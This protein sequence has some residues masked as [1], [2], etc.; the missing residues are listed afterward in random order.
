M[1]HRARDPGNGGAIRDP[2]ATAR[3]DRAVPARRLRVRATRF[4]IMALLLLGLAFA[5]TAVQ[6]QCY[7]S[8]GS[9]T[10]VTFSPPSTITIPVGTPNNTVIYT[11]PQV[12]PAAPPVVTCNPAQYLTYGVNNLLGSQPATSATIFPTSVPGIGYRLLHPDTSYYLQPYPCCIQYMSQS[13]FSVQSAIQLIKTGPVT[14]GS[15]LPAGSFANW[16]WGSLTPETFVMGN[17][18]TFAQAGCQV[19]NSNILVVLPTL[20]TSAFS[21]RNSTAGDT[22]FAIN[23]TCTSGATLNI[24]LDTTRPD[25]RRPGVIRTSG[26]G[27]SAGGI[28][29]QVLDG[30]G[31]PV[32]FGTTTTVGATP[33]GGLSVPY[34][35]RYIQRGGGVSPGSVSA[36]ATFTLS[37]Q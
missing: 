16:Q 2:R 20:T 13:T 7:Y 5:A 25:N 36:T 22:A 37:Y 35:A 19:N 21:G 10:T 3:M 23:L 11:S 12:A 24:T 1:S 27:G 4:A 33:D 26:G 9:A 8:S 18:V 29:V 34:V 32:S 28:G 30:S 14:P 15:V 31:T 6:A 17:S